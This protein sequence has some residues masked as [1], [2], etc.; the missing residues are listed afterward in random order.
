MGGFTFVHL[1]WGVEFRCTSTL[2]LHFRAPKR[3]RGRKRWFKLLMEV[4][5]EWVFSEEFSVVVRDLVHL[6]WW[7]PVL[8][9]RRTFVHHDV[10]RYPIWLKMG[11]RFLVR[12]DGSDFL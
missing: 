6:V 8:G 11:I 9:C 3:I 1:N 10:F 12:Q 4:L 5:E 2:P 7:N